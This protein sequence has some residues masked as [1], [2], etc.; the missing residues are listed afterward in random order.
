MKQTNLLI[1][2]AVITFPL[3]T[4]Y[5]GENPTCSKTGYVFGYG[6]FAAGYE[7]DLTGTVAHFDFGGGF[8][9]GG[10]VGIYS[11]LLCGSRFE[12]EGLFT[13]NDIESVTDVAGITEGASGGG[14]NT[15]AVMVNALKEIPFACVTGFVGA[16]V[17]YAGTELDDGEFSVDSGA[18]AYQLIA[19]GEMPI[20][21][22]LA[23]FAQYKLLGIGETDYLV[24]GDTL[25]FDSY[26]I[27]SVSA[28]LRFSF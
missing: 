13:S 26:F 16:G 25:N 11:D 4:M 23:L 12:I 3:T 22:C 6:G 9:A 8:I 1:F 28:G 20:S 15:R 14:I 10:G 5:A 27:H 17:G 2:C 18:V 7:L 21:D 24:D 19:G